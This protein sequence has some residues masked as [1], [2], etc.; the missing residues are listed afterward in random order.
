MRGL[1]GVVDVRQDREAIEIQASDAESVVRELFAL[2][3]HL[4][5]LEVTRAGLEDAFIALTQEDNNLA[6][7]RR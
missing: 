1:P 3:A 2:D 4:S 6:G 5:G 7:A